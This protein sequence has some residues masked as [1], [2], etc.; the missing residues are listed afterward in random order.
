MLSGKEVGRKNIFINFMLT[1]KRTE[2]SK[3]VRQAKKDKHIMR[4][5]IDQNLSFIFII[6]K[7]G[8]AKDNGAK[9]P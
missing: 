8:R 5:S 3:L 1:A 7:K 4:Y 9:E 2:L 6:R